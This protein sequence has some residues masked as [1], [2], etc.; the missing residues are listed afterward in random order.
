MKKLIVL[1]LALT[2]CLSM[3]ACGSTNQSKTENAETEISQPAEK[4]QFKEFSENVENLA[5][6]SYVELLAQLNEDPSE[7]KIYTFA[8]DIIDSSIIIDGDILSG[9]KDD[10]IPKGSFLYYIELD[11]GVHRYSYS[12]GEWKT[13]GMNFPRNEFL[14]S[15]TDGYLSEESQERVNKEIDK[16]AEHIKNGGSREIETS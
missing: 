5:F 3:C 16:Y 10:I 12:H 4:Y 8:C 2:M 14:R 6:Y 9:A 7:C 11:N 1:G 13:A 15:T